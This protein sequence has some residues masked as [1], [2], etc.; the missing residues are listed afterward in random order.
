MAPITKGQAKAM[1]AYILT[2]ILGDDETE[3]GDA[4]DNPGPIRLA[5]KKAKVKGILDLNSMSASV[6]ESLKY[7]DSDTKTL[8]PLEKGEIGW[9]KTFRS[10]IYYRD[11]INESLD[12]ND[13][14]LSLQ[15]ED[16]QRF[17]VSKE[18]F[19]I[20]E[21][22]GK[23]LVS[24]SSRGNNSNSRDAVANFK[25]GIKRDIGLFSTL[26]QDKQWD[27][28]QRATIA[29]ARAQDLSEVLDDNYVPVTPTDQAL[30]QEKKKYMYAVFERTLLSDKGK[31]LVREHTAD[32]DAQQVYSELCAY[33]LKSTKATIE[34]SNILTYITSSRLGDGTWKSDTHSYLLHWRDQVRKYE[35]LIP[36]PDHFSDG[37]KRTMLENAVH[38]ISD[39][40]Q[41]RI[42]ALHDKVQTGK[43][44]TYDQ[45]VSLLLSGAM[46]YDPQLGDSKPARSRAQRQVYAHDIDTEPPTRQLRA[47]T[48]DI[49]TH[50]G[51]DHGYDHSSVSYNEWEV[52]NASYDKGPRLSKDRW[53]RLPSDART[54]WDELSPESKHIILEAKTRHQP[55]PPR[56]ANLHELTRGDIDAAAAYDFIQAHLHDLQLTENTVEP[57]S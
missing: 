8:I 15:L 12:S 13:A 44:I 51:Y 41:V 45:Y 30:F 31:A 47:Y 54:K 34:S 4:D 33:A 40:R 2:D 37:Q 19:T 25:R 21:N 35:D 53:A 48:H 14:W 43:A 39:L 32:F 20:S 38:N 50:L 26:K 49:D 23:A 16:F 6:L 17:R 9:L 29:Q 11:S 1:L 52:Y 18:W 36:K 56:K 46:I 57:P 28:W 24:S 22:P 55:R 27:V 42:Q 10:Y 5:L 7:Y 3:V